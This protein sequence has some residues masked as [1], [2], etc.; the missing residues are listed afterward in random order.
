MREAD[1][2]RRAV[3]TGIGPVTPIGTGVE[4]FWQSLS[5]GRSGARLVPLLAE[6]GLKT[7]IACDIPDF[8]PADYMDPKDAKRMARF[9]QL[10]V[11][12][13]HLA[14][15]DAGLDAADLASD[16]AAAVV[17]TGGGGVTTIA[18]QTEVL[19]ARG[20]ARVSPFF[21]PM[22]A[23]NM[24]SCQ[25]SIQLGMRGPAVTSLAACAS[26][27]Y[28]F[29]D[30]RQMLLDGEAELVLAGG[31]ESNVSVLGIAGL[32]NMHALS[33][34][35]EEPE[36]ASRPFDAER[37]GF[38]FGEGAVICAVETLERARARG[39]RV[40]AEVL[41]GGR[42]A[43]A[44]H[45]T[46]PDPS[47]DGMARAM[48]GALRHAGLNA[49]EVGY[50]SAHGTSTPIND[51]VETS[52]IRQVFGGHAD[53]LAVSSTKSMTGHLMGAAGA[54]SGAA[55]ALAIH[56]GALPPTINLETPDPDCD[57]DYVPNEAR[58][59]EV[60]AALVNG[61]GFGGQN[62][63]VALGRASG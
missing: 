56:R 37:D 59:A 42:T 44:H 22:M 51:R 11:A 19:G 63:V 47:G 7:Q 50:I 16:R 39:A 27:I 31:T 48:S 13:A 28:A 1:P 20:P 32:A 62:G 3:I 18:D 4:A 33:R 57:L 2:A 40:Y 58:E 9:S 17:N 52:A 34:R 45:I 12:A 24:A 36:R 43:D 55:T 53:G 60:S 29:I 25:V 54:L 46:A 14:A 38:V 15:A 35:N 5:E 26:S 8:E 61:F 23:A 10:A 41:G 30:A 6:A 21:V 49:E